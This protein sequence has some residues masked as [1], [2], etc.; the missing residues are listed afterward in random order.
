[1]FFNLNF[2]DF[3]LELP[4]SFGGDSCFFTV[5]L[6]SLKEFSSPSAYK[7]FFDFNYNENSKI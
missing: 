4:F 2:T 3:P 6:T 1:L 7:M 5:Y